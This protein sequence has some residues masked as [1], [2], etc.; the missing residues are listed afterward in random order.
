VFISVFGSN[1][2]AYGVE[3]GALT[4]DY[5]DLYLMAAR[6]RVLVREMS[7]PL[8]MIRFALVA[9]YRQ[10]RHSL[11]LAPKFSMSPSYD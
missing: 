8:S 3:Y 7:F 6:A 1:S 5:N 9:R 4:A 2:Y 11:S 10:D